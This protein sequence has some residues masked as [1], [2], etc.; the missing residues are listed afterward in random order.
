MPAPFST[1]RT[2]GVRPKKHLGQHFL[3]DLSVAQRIADALTGN[4][5]ARVLEVGPGTGV[6]T[7]FLRPRWGDA[8]TVVELDEESVAYLKGSF[9]LPESQILQ[10][11]FLHMP[12]AQLPQEAFCVCGNFPYNISSQIVFRVLDMRQHVPELVGMFQREVAQ[13]IAIGPGTKEYGIL[14]VLAQAWYDITYLFTVSEGVFNPPPKV[15]SGVIR[16][17][18]NSRQALPCNEKLFV[19]VVKTSFNQRR[20]VLSNSL[21]PLLNGAIPPEEP[22]WKLRPERLSVDEFVALTNAVEQL[23]ATPRS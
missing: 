18:R 9:G 22:I 2:A 15:K 13:R 6:L 21:K 1:H 7:Q 17:V 11:D 16:M 10:G 20:K 5:Y 23:A 4:G 3:T 8:L 19:Q 12:E 14:S